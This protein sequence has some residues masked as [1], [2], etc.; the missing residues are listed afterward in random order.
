MTRIHDKDM[1][2][3][4]IGDWKYTYSGTLF[5][6]VDV[7]KKAW[8]YV[9]NETTRMY[10]ALAAILDGGLTPEGEAWCWDK[11]QDVSRGSPA[12]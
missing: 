10:P 6:A 7:R 2:V 5:N 12:S 3:G 11:L 4:I 1:P 9:P 8:E